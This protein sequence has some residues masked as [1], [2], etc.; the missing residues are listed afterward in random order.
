L[1]QLLVHK[2]FFQHIIQLQ[3]NNFEKFMATFNPIIPTYTV[4]FQNSASILSGDGAH[5]E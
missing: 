1:E 2:M 5:E 3:K 4:T